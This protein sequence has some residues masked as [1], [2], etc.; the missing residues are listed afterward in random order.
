MRHFAKPLLLVAL[1]LAIPIVPFLVFG[2]ALQQWIEAWM[3]PPPDRLTIA[4]MITCVMA[5]DVFLPIPSSVLSTYAGAQ[6]GV[7]L[8][9]AATWLGMTVG[10]VLG[11]GL[12]RRLGRPL[13]E[14]L[15]DPDLLAGMEQWTDRLG[16]TVL[17]VC[18]AVP[19]VAEASVLVTGAIGLEWR[20]FLPVV[21]ASNLGIA[22]AYS[23]F[24]QVAE[25]HD[26]L[27][28][29]LAVSVAIP[30]AVTALLRRR[31]AAATDS[32]G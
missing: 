18:R 12:A 14:R 17:V 10:A 23:A 3:D 22:L 16:P 25:R 11:F 30:L 26:W 21:V 13:A 4:A 7:A 27:P 5:T 24:G 32:D 29:A 31:L 9:T 28:V 1:V 2:E 19:V 6:L 20:R 8:G 15:A